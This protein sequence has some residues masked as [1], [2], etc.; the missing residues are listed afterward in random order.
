MSTQ[1]HGTM[2]YETDCAT[3]FS[4]LRDPEYIASKLR[5][6]GGFD[7]DVTVSDEGS[8]VVIV[9]DRSLPA[10]IPAFAKRFTG[11]TI[12]VHEVDTWSPA[13]EFGGRTGRAE[14]DFLHT[15]ASASGVL[16]LQPT[17]TGCE[18]I[19][20]LQV[21]AQI[22]LVGGKIAGEIA[23]QITRAIRQENKIGVQWL[24][25]RAED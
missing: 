13:D 16:S 9:A 24:A 25:D 1:V 21:N 18:M 12:R 10:Q 11:D 14:L 5:G 19:V 8:D 2:T 20:D 7:P 22:P 4:M 17:P 15:P 3:V 23:H 6:T